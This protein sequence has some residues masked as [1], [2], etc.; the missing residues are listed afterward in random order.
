MLMRSG[1]RLLHG[2]ITYAMHTIDLVIQVGRR[3]GKR[4]VPEIYLPSRDLAYG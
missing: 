2:E 4:G 3:N 1:V